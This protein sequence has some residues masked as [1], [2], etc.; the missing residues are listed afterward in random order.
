MESKKNVPFK[1]GI[2]GDVERFEVSVSS[3]EQ[4]KLLR[5]RQMM[6]FVNQV[7]QSNQSM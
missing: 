7:K 2:A 6:T 5:M 3:G 4:G 1:G